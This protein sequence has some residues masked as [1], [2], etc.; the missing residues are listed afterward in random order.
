M[1]SA[2]LVASLALSGCTHADLP[3]FERV[4]ASQDSATAALGQWC[5]SQ[6]IAQPPVIRAQADRN[7]QLAPTA[8]VRAVLDVPDG[9]PVSYRHV[10]LACGNTVLSVAHNWFVPARLAPGMSH[11]LDTTDIPFGKVVAPLGFRRERLAAQRG[12]ATECPKGTVL[13]HRAVLRLADGKAIS[14]VI[15]CYTRANLKRAG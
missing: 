14:L 8:A 2:L 3:R 12:Q 7:A 4:M 13:S 10:R 11:T 6:K 5:G 15:E 1:R 9:T